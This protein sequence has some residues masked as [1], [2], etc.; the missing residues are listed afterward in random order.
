MSQEAVPSTPSP[1]AA[2]RWPTAAWVFGAWTLVG[3][4]R[5]ADRYFSDSFQLQRLEFGLW[6]ALAQSLLSA[7]IWA[8]LTPLVVALAR[9]SLPSRTR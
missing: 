3:L 7:Y 1:R 4:F 2:W 8:A 5:A 6:E 9:H